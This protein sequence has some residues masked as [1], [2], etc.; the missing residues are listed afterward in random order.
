MSENHKCSL[1]E[2]Q[3]YWRIG[4][5]RMI[6]SPGF[7]LQLDIAREEGLLAPLLAGDSDTVARLASEC[8]ESLSARIHWVYPSQPTEQSQAEPD[9]A[10]LELVREIPE[11]MGLEP[12]RPSNRND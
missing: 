4:Q 6:A 11:N 9:Q 3:A 7:A 1:E 12:S 8:I 10:A 5:I 2:W